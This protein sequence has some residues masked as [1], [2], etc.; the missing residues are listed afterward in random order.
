MLFGGKEKKG[1][2]RIDT[3]REK[4]TKYLMVVSWVKTLY[5]SLF[6]NIYSYVFYVQITLLVRL[7]LPQEAVISSHI[8]I[9]AN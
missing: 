5:F 2:L 6:M 1:V 8:G 9:K 4:K 7:I 3:Y